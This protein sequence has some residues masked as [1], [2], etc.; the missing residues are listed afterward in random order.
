M[1]ATTI[2]YSELD[3]YRQC[4]F[5]HQ[6][7][8]RERWV[9]GDTPAALARGTAWHQI[10]DHHYRT[11][12]S[13]QQGHI[14]RGDLKS[15]LHAGIDPILQ[16]QKGAPHRDDWVGT[17]GDLLEWMYLGYV[18]EY[19]LD[20]E[21]EVVAVEHHIVGSLPTDRGGASRIRIKGKVD[22]IVKWAGKLWVVDHK[23]GKDL[24]KDKDLDFDDQFGVYT[25][26]MRNSGHEVFGQIY[27]AAR[28]YKLKTRDMGPDERYSR[29]PMH[30]TDAELD[31]LAVEAYKTARNAYAAR[32]YGGDAPRSVDSDRCGW[33]CNYT[34][35][36]LFGRKRGDNSATRE[37]LRDTGFRQDFTRH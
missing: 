1:T 28:T 23:T 34:E 8:Y 26:L 19:G 21:W 12:Q 14:S 15:A 32:G 24:P 4:P 25:W 35:A 36:C 2:S 33:R 11:V 3:S 17:E 16:E 20:P 31:V 27:N 6:L 5:K 37:F 7:A 10:M 18:D 29:H 9:S 13:H 22:L 30:R